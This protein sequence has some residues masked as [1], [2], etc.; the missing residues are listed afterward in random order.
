MAV[1]LLW[2]PLVGEL[3][4][5]TLLLIAATTLCCGVIGTAAGLGGGADGFAGAT[6][7]RGA[8][9]RA[10]RDPAFYYE[11]CLGVA[12][13]RAGG[14]FGRAAGGDGLVLSAG[15]S[16]GGGR[17]A[18]DGPGFGRDRAGAGEFA[19]GG[20]LACRA[21]AASP[22]FAGGDAAGGAGYAGGIRGVCAAAVPHVHHG[23]LFGLSG[24]VFG[25]GAGL[26]VDDSVG[27]VRG[28]PG[29]GIFRARPGAVWAAGA[30]DAAGGGAAWAGALA[31]CCLS[32]G[33]RAGR[34]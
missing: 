8:G 3:L 20:V 9:G 2:R 13:P 14:F 26:A 22:G 21:A 24:R 31:V 18:G 23:D 4:S 15:L 29:G 16:A 1:A 5:N 32:P 34:C 30:R 27:A 33:L 10:A 17:V 28:L 19:L 6:W 11:L 12:Q 25:R 7:L